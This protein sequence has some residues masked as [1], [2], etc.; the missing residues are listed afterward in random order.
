M[1]GGRVVIIG[2]TGRNFGAGMSGGIAYV[3]DADGD[4]RSRCN[5]EMILLERLDE[6]EDLD[7]VKGLLER[8]QEYTDSTVAGNI[9]KNWPD[10]AA[11]FV[12]V[13]PTE[14]R[15]VLDEQ[16]EASNASEELV[17]PNG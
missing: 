5:M 10:E 14:Y 9:L 1:T 17:A 6:A 2:K 7:L 11:S 13:M 3:Y 12:K 4:F 16:A 15:R 8:H